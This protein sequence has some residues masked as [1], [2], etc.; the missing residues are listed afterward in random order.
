[1]IS[2]KTNPKQTA[3]LAVI[4]S[5]FLALPIA[6]VVNY[7]YS[8]LGRFGLLVAGSLSLIFVCSITRWGVFEVRKPVRWIFYVSTLG[9]FSSMIDITIGLEND[10]L[11]SNMMTN[12]LN[13]GE[14]Y[15]T[16]AHG[17]MICYYDGILHYIMYLILLYRVTYNK[18][19]YEVGLFWAGSLGHSMIVFM[20]GNIVGDHNLH[21]SI[22]LNIPYVIIP[23]ASGYMFYQQYHI[24]KTTG[25]FEIRVES[26]IVKMF[27][28]VLFTVLILISLF[29]G[30]AVLNH[31]KHDIFAYYIKNVEP[32][33]IHTDAYPKLQAQVTHVGASLRHDD[34][35]LMNINEG[36]FLFWMINLL[37]LIV[38]QCFLVLACHY[39]TTD[40][41][42]SKTK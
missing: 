36:S 2:W 10:K 7:S 6:Y 4:F 42:A 33:L 22:F 17:T 23:F 12:Y 31:T 8:I 39:K 20:P 11:V 25:K 16:T 41:L 9:M 32:Y 35:T 18:S 40:R 27:F 15:L 29:R 38:P 30:L 13:T 26:T 21:P 3:S 37:L 28:A 1:M 34:G 24:Q 5:S 14:P 19:C